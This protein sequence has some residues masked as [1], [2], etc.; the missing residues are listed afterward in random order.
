MMV[1]RDTS[2]KKNFT[3]GDAALN[4]D[5]KRVG[6]TKKYHA[7]EMVATHIIYTDYF[8]RGNITSSWHFV[9]SI[10]N[11]CRMQTDSK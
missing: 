5:N 6:T 7:N 10:W 2:P 9:T 4:G 8:F 1:A 11:R 3:Y